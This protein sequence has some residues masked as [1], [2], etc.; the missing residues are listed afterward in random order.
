M[1]YNEDAIGTTLQNERRRLDAGGA[2]PARAGHGA[3]DI[4]FLASPA[5]LRPCETCASGWYAAQ[6]CA[7]LDITTNPIICP[8]RQSSPITASPPLLLPW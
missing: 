6:W 3:H 2:A 7:A 4:L 8:H 1:R 5:L